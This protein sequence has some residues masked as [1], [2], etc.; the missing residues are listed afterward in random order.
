AVKADLLSDQGEI[1]GTG[2]RFDA[3]FTALKDARNDIAHTGAYARH[4]AADAVDLS[5]LFEEALMNMRMTVQD[6]MVATP[7]TVQPWQSVGHARQLMLL[8]SFS[9]L[10]MWDGQSWY[11]LSDT[12]VAKYLRPDWPAKSKK[13]KTIQ[14]ASADGLMLTTV[15][16][17]DVQDLVTDLL[18]DS[19]LP[20]LWVVVQKGFPPGH[21]AGVLSPFE[22]M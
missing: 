20:D 22:L 7:I 17:V 15:Q 2:R 14:E 3:L 1:Y 16:P 6:F 11:L 21:L 13:S 9:Y 5:L 4:V 19:E 18:K 10:P 8:N 12:A